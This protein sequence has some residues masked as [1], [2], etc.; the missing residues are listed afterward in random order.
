MIPVASGRTCAL[1][2]RAV[3]LGGLTAA[4]W[5]ISGAIAS[6]S[7]ADTPAEP[8]TTPA[9]TE[10]TQPAEKPQLLTDPAGWAL[11]LTNTT[12][13]TAV[14]ATST[15]L[16]ASVATADTGL[17]EVSTMAS[18]E[19]RKPGKVGADRPK[20]NK[21]KKPA[22]QPATE[23]DEGPVLDFSG[24][25]DGKGERSGSVSNEAPAEVLAAKAEAR[26]AKKAAKAAA[27]APAPAPAPAAPV[28]AAALKI[29]PPAPVPAPPHAQQPPAD[30]G[31][32][33]TVP[34][35]PNPMP[36]PQ[37]APASTAPSVSSGH[38]DNSGGTRGVLAVLPSHS[39]LFP[40]TTWTVEERTDG[41]SPG[42]LP[43]LP[44]TSPD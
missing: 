33:W 10:I 15:T 39:A 34:Q 6:A 36:V 1:L 23:E 16:N 14:N 4:A 22:K 28:P 27:L 12:L 20:P 29:Q 30:T 43:G 19:K 40:P 41:R 26:A 35:P 24:G 25:T 44:S 2:L 9:A 3:A 5:L 11:A 8:V 38:Q 42:S 18:G 31:A 21:T 32:D 17:T 7:P 13:S 37:P